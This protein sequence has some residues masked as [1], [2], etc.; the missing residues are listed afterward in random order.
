[1]VW[2]TYFFQKFKPKDN[3]WKMKSWE[4]QLR[5]KEV[6]MWVLYMYSNYTTSFH[7]Q[8]TSN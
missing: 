5:S 2:D 7:F 4:Q 8:S 3:I 1:M 6:I